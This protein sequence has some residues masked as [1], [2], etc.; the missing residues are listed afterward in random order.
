MDRFTIFIIVLGGFAIIAKIALIIL[1]G[2]GI[3]LLFD[4]MP[5]DLQ[6]ACETILAPKHCQ[7]LK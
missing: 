1:T 4:S 3:Y 2:Y 6:L 7:A 5:W